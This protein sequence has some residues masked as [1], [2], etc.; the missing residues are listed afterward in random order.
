MVNFSFSLLSLEYYLLILVRIASFVAVAPFF[1]L[2]AVPT[3]VKIGLSATIAM[4]VFQLLPDPNLSYDG[5]ISYGLIV[6]KEAATGLMIGA[7]ANMCTY[8]VSFAG[9]IIDMQI[10]LSMA[11]QYNPMTRA[12]ES[13]TGNFYNYAVLLLLLT[14]NMY[15]Y[16][17]QAIVDSFTLV[18]VNGQIFQW[19]YL[20]RSMITFVTELFSIGFRISLPIFACMM[21]FDCVLGIMAKVA[22]QMNMFAV[23]IQIKL[24]MG[25]SVIM[26]SVVLLP[27]VAEIIGEEMKLMM[28]M[29]VKGLYAG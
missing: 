10:G 19:E 9:H 27:R 12:Q 1:G 24:L 25:Y 21:A 3:R 5:M 15:H 17:I 28:R 2:N 18:P 8:I 11:Q 26:L 20:V 29:M 14:S 16:I 6:L 13:I 22:P 23:G 7:A 4:I